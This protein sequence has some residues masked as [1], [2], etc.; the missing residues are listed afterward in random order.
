[1][2]EVD[3]LMQ[4][5][6][7]REELEP[8]MDESVQIVDLER[9]P[10]DQENAYLTSLL[11]WERAPV[12]P[13]SEWFEPPLVLEAH[14]RFSNEEIHSRVTWLIHLLAEKNVVLEMTEHL[15]DRQLY[16]LISRDI[17]PSQEKRVGLKESVLRWQCID[18]SEDEESWLR[19]YA[20]DEERENWADDTGLRLPPKETRRF[21]R[22][23]TE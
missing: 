7:L 5:A 8:F 16:C 13:I 9:L 10:T 4:N 23:M 21:R 22:D 6:R 18:P 14:E 15:S 11:A 19:Y 1:M 3:L 12:L 17:L 20:T 2:N